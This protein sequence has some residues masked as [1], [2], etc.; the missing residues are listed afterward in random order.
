MSDFVWRPTD[1][2][3]ERANVTR[4]A[5]AHGIS[6]Y[7]ELLKRSIDDIEWFWDAA[8]RDLGLDGA[9]AKP[10]ERVLELPRG[11][12]WPLW[13]VGGEIN[14]AYACVDRH[15]GSDSVALVWE[16]EEGATRSMSYDELSSEVARLAHA[17]AGIGVGR[18]DAV[19]LFLPMIPE[20]VVTFMAACRLGAI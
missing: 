11:I 7:D 5:R 12:Q 15:V 2:V 10:Y 3:I 13:F 1:E 19:G 14:I 18:G 16:G 9:F 20:A 8:V 4:L 6:S 17:L